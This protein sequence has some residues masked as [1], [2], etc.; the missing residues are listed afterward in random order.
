M[1]AKFNILFNKCA[2]LK[3]CILFNYSS[4]TV[5]VNTTIITES[6]LKNI[7][8]INLSLLLA[9]ALF[10][11]LPFLPLSVQISRTFSRT[12]F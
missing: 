11:P 4:A 10:T 12:I 9:L 1:Y 2:S 6:P 7:F 5:L 8:P 3:H